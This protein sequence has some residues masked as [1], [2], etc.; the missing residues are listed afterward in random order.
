MDDG[1]VWEFSGVAVF[2]FSFWRV[3]GVGVYGCCRFE[4]GFRHVV[5]AVQVSCWEGI[6][7]SLCRVGVWAHGIARHPSRRWCGQLIKRLQWKSY[8]TATFVYCVYW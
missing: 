8:D 2:F 3:V 6:S 1:D 4:E 7:L 5:N